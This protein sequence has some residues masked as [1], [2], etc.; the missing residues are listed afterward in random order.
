LV[1]GKEKEKE[2]RRQGEKETRRQGDK[3]SLANVHFIPLS[4][5]LLVSLPFASYDGHLE[6]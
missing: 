1:E 6:L 3:E 2:T 5:S 4:P